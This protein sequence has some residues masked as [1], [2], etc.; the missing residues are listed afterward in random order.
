MTPG[1]LEFISLFG[2][3]GPAYWE[4]SESA[5]VLNTSPQLA[6]ETMGEK[7]YFRGT[8]KETKNVK[9]STEVLNIQSPFDVFSILLCIM[10]VKW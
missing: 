4:L 1:C 2:R 5:W 3:T 6:G 9:S 7:K 8:T 10:G